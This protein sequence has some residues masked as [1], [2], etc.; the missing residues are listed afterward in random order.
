M[1]NNLDLLRS[2]TQ[3]SERSRWNIEN[4]TSWKDNNTQ[5]V[6]GDKVILKIFYLQLTDTRS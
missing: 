4:Y 1:D 3:S 5:H 2:A 6:F